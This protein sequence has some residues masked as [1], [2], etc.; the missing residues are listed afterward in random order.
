MGW[1]TVR[2]DL[3]AVRADLDRVTVKAVS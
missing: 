1:R 3:V 2:F